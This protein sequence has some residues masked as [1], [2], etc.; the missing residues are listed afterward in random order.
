[1]RVFLFS[2]AGLMMI[3]G[4][5]SIALG[6][7]YI[8][9][10]RGWTQVIAGASLFAG[11]AVL[12]GLAAV[13]TG[14]DRLVLALSARK[15]AATPTASVIQ[16]SVAPI[17]PKPQPLGEAQPASPI[18]RPANPALEWDAHGEPPVTERETVETVEPPQPLATDE[19][20][21]APLTS[22]MTKTAIPADAQSP[23]AEE[24]T[25]SRTAAEAA[26]PSQTEHRPDEAAP[27]AGASVEI[28][29]AQ[30]E[31]GPLRPAEPVVMGRYEAKDASYVMFSDGSIEANTKSGVFRFGSMS[32]LKA[33]IEGQA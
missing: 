13:V 32:E 22:A 28:E 18:V 8:Q 26:S 4:A 31:P 30:A 7:D 24:A 29:Q 11:G 3:A 16:P 17:A 2:F 15:D 21:H 5:V 27:P 6:I 14:L 20:R 12:L 10:E 1:M 33:F 23:L 9:I 19:T 25:E